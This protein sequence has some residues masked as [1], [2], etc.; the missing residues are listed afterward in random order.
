M[1]PLAAAAPQQADYL[2]QCSEF[3][4]RA[5]SDLQISTRLLTTR[6]VI[7]APIARGSDRSEEGRDPVHFGAN[8]QPILNWDVPEQS[9]FRMMQ[10]SLD[11][12]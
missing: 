1:W 3:L 2:L 12:A 9:I 11:A 10:R 6:D 5:K 4:Q 8:G 7:P